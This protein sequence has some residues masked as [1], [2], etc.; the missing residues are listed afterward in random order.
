LVGG[1]VDTALR[2]PIQRPVSRG[3]EATIAG[4]Q[5]KRR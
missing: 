1:G 5:A 3:R 4:H 2:I